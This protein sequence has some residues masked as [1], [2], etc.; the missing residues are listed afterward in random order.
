M[1]N[2]PN[3]RVGLESARVAAESLKEE[4]LIPPA[5]SSAEP[6]GAPLGAVKRKPSVE[7]KSSPAKKKLAKPTPEQSKA[8]PVP[9]QKPSKQEDRRPTITE[10]ASSHAH[11]SSKDA[12][13]ID[14]YSYDPVDDEPEDQKPESNRPALIGY[15]G[16]AIALLMPPLFRDNELSVAAAALNQWAE[17][18]EVNM[19]CYLDGSRIVF[20]KKKTCLCPETP[21]PVP[22]KVNPT[23]CAMFRPSRYKDETR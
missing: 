10:E 23:N 9:P 12:L 13:E 7:A 17:T 21:P 3:L 16:S 20:Q 1:D 4:D 11:G 5:S 15:S 22:S 6:P 8:A 14:L 18:E 19:V 2:H